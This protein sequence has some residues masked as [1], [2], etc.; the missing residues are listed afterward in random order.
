MPTSIIPETEASVRARLNVLLLQRA[1]LDNKFITE[2]KK[3]NGF[4]ADQSAP[5]RTLAQHQ[6]NI[7]ATQLQ[8]PQGLGPMAYQS[9]IQIPIT[10]ALCELL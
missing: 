6:L 10:N 5:Q 3:L 9:H 8:D 7:A 4:S 2:L 1:E